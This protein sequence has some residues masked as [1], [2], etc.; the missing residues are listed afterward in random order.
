[1]LSFCDILFILLQGSTVK[2][3]DQGFLE[4]PSFNIEKAEQCLEVSYFMYSHRDQ[5]C[6]T[7]RFLVSLECGDQ[8]IELFRRSSAEERKWYRTYT[9]V[10]EAVGSKCKVRI[11]LHFAKKAVCRSIFDMALYFAELTKTWF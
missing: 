8:T 4:S 1:V 6:D 2:K 5:R 10:E 3:E 7:A 11:L 9:T